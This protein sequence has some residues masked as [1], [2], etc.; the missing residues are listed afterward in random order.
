MDTIPL[1]LVDKADEPP[2]L[3]LGDLDITRFVASDGLRIDYGGEAVRRLGSLPRS[4]A[5]V[6]ITFAPGRLAL[7]FDI[8]LLERLLDDARTKAGA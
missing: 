1:R 6:T 8:D 7:D 3:L 4:L 5:E 2:R